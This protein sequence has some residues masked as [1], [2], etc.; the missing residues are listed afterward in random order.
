MFEFTY[1]PIL[2]QISRTVWPAGTTGTFC[3]FFFFNLGDFQDYWKPKILK[4]S[5][6]TMFTDIYLSRPM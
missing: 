5:F 3:I 2:A 1:T 4:S 6:Y